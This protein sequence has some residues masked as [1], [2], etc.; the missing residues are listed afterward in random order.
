MTESKTRTSIKHAIIDKTNTRIVATVAVAVFIVIFCLFSIRSLVS[1]GLY[2]NRVISE[3]KDALSELK[4]NRSAITELQES[5]ESFNSEVVNVLGGN[6]SGDGPTD[7]ENVKIVLDSLP[8]EYDYPALSSSIEKILSENG[9][10]IDSIGGTEDPSQVQAGSE[11]VSDPVPIEIS[12]PIAVDSDA[13]GIRL[14][15][16][17]TEKS[18][19]PFVIES[20]EL[21]G[22]GSNLSAEIS[23]KT[24]YMPATGFSVGSKVVR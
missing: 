4:K 13:L 2:Q 8:S 14:L 5:Y 22:S 9:Y 21:S 10:T 15:L 7:G 18:I 16:E 12:Y 6:P 17:K 23:M 3:K 24:Y 11:T 20:F 1:Q 19:R